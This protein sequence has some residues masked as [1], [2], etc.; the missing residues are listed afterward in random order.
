[1]NGLVGFVNDALHGP[2]GTIAVTLADQ[3]RHVAMEPQR[4][5][6]GPPGHEFMAGAARQDS[7]HHVTEGSKH[8]VS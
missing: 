7:G 5:F 8:G 1:M 4:L 6:I 2:A 3:S